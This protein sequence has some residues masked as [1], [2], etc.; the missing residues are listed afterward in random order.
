M[1][2][3]DLLSQTVDTLSLNW[4]YSLSFIEGFRS[5]L[6]NVKFPSGE[7]NF[8]MKPRVQTPRPRQTNINFFKRVRLH[9]VNMITEHHKIDTES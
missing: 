9:L 7:D 5:V 3:L 6:R 2:Y 4:P 8:L 1:N